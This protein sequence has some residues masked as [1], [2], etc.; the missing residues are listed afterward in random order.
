MAVFAAVVYERGYAATRLTDVAQRA[1]VPATT[2][3]A[4]WPTEVDWLLETV[5]ASTRQLFARVAD[6]FMGIP[7]DAPRALHQGL[8]AMLRDMAA[9]PEMVHLSMVELPALGPLVPPPPRP[10]ARPL[11]RLPRSRHRRAR[12]AAPEHRRHHA[13]HHRRS[14][15]A[16]PPPRPRAPPARAPGYPAVRQPRAPVDAV[17][18]RRGDARR[19]RSARVQRELER[20]RRDDEGII[21]VARR[22]AGADVVA[23]LQHR[24]RAD[25]VAPTRLPARGQQPRLDHRLEVA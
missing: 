19:G 4:H 23:H 15:G 13:L 17:R 8:A 14:L 21:S 11:P 22:A 18:P 10:R 1:G 24:W 6:A 20:V 7:D 25:V 16:H 9:A 2:L 5:T 3:I 12:R